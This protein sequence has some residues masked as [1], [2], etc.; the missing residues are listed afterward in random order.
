MIT[1]LNDKLIQ[2]NDEVWCFTIGIAKV[3]KADDSWKKITVFTKSGTE[4][5]IYPKDTDIIKVR[6]WKELAKEALDIQNACNLSGLVY[7]FAAIIKEIRCRLNDEG[8]NSTDIINT[9]PICILFT[10]KLA[11]LASGDNSSLNFWKAYDWAK[12]M[13]DE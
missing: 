12:K 13:A 10:D 2:V 8:V 3:I 9:H 4:I 6:S 5:D 11:S 1:D 7:A